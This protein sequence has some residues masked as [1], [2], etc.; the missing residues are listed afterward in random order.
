MWGKCRFINL[1]IIIVAIVAFFALGQVEKQELKIPMR[2]GAELAADLYLPTDYSQ[3]KH[4]EGV[5]VILVIT[6]YDRIRERAIARWRDCFVMNGY[7][8]V[9]QDMRG[10]YGSA[11][12]G[13]G[14]QRKF[15]G[16]DTIQ[17]LADQDWCNGKVGMM[18][19]SHLG[20]VQYE[21]A[22]S[23]PP[24]LKG[25]IPAQAP[26]NYYTDSLYPPVFRKADMET[27]LR[28]QFSS[29]TRMLIKRRG[30]S[31]ERGSF[32]NFNAPMIHSAGWYDFYTEG[33]IEMFRALRE[34]GSPGAREAQK[35]HI[36]PWSHGIL[37]EENP[38]RP[39]VLPSGVSYPPN[40]KP[41][42]EE[43]FW[44]PWFDFWCKGEPTGIMD[45]PAVKYYL[46][47]ATDNPGAPG[48]V[49]VEADDFPPP[50]DAITYFIHSDGSL[51][52]I[53][54]AA[55]AVISFDYDPQ[56]PVPTAGWTHIRLPAR[57]PYD[58]R[59]VEDRADVLLFTTEALEEP[60][61]I[62][63]QIR[64]NLWAS[65]NRRDTDFTAKLTDVYS[66]GRS[67]LIT[68]GIVK[69]RYRNTMLDEEFLVPGQICEFDIDLGYTAIALAPGHRLRLAI[70]S[71][72]FPRFDINPNTGE[73]YGDH[74]TSR[75]LLAERLRAEP[76]RGEPA[77]TA[78]LIA[79][80]SIYMGAERSSQVILPI[81]SLEEINKGDI[82]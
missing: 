34:H 2:D 60:L 69:A 75:K 25:A 62:V 30:R 66:D 15:D 57:G 38:G 22:D 64:V 80:N 79:T 55:E 40:S 11:E 5:P 4:P 26:G 3:K 43:E 7:A 31:L 6:P 16:F 10:F 44:L 32:Q 46:M 77:F 76:V 23:D 1:S 29:R 74:A 58:Q 39:L 54:P 21:T 56:N 63:G 82:H 65:S 17:W 78:T 71:S 18:G 50:A 67:M 70:S 28:G 72:N 20:A 35:L 47:G 68:D 61:V 42:W 13:R 51:T 8:F 81:I 9:A 24:A 52:T 45:E 73:P 53:E 12:A 59:Q 36:G 14:V 19:Y 27:I 33:A 48:N 41:S 49:W 37:Q